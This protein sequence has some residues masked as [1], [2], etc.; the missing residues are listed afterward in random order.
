MDL[1]Q[2]TRDNLHLFLP[3]LILLPIN[4]RRLCAALLLRL[5]CLHPLLHR[6]MLTQLGQV[7]VL[8]TEAVQQRTVGDGIED[9]VVVRSDMKCQQAVL[10][11]IRS[12]RRFQG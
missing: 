7:V 10:D 6:E 1:R 3:I 12:S 5:T 4:L 8:Q 9:D 2:K 11:W